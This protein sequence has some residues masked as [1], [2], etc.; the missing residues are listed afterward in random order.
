MYH[1]VCLR[2]LGISNLLHL[3]PHVAWMGEMRNAYNI[4]VG[5]DLKHI[6]VNGKVFLVWILGK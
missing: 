4:F 6:G 2:E 1:I 3:F 5:K